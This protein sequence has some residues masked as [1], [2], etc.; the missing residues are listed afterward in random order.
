MSRTKNSQ[1]DKYKTLD[2]R[3]IIY[4]VHQNMYYIYV[5]FFIEIML[6]ALISAHCLIILKT[7]PAKT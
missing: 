6:N 1:F 2:V 5:A 4:I 3:L 7:L